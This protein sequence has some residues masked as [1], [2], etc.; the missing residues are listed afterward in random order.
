MMNTSTKWEISETMGA[1]KPKQQV[2]DENET[3]YGP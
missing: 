3:S 2:D 1:D